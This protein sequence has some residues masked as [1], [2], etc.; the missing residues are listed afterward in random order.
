MNEEADGS[1]ISN[2]APAGS[3]WA[4]LASFYIKLSSNLYPGLQGW[5]GRLTDTVKHVDHQPNHCALGI[6]PISVN[7]TTLATNGFFLVSEAVPTVRR[8]CLSS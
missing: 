1:I 4:A 5:G 3:A 8:R 6:E 7:I 2:Q